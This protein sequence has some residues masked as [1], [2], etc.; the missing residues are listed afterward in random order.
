MA[1]VVNDLKSELEERGEYV[2]LANASTGWFAINAN[3]W[4]IRSEQATRDGRDGPNL[5][6]YR[7]TSG[8]PRDHY[9]VPYPV[10]RDLLTKD[11]LKP[12]ANG[13]QR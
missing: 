10:V 4:R 11:T 13:Y 7:T 2:V 3:T 5:I 6:F 12:Q 1:S 9:A 8:D